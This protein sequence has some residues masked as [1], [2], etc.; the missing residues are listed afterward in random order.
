MAVSIPT[1]QV[2][3]VKKFLSETS[4][5]HSL[6]EYGQN[7]LF[8]GDNI[9][10]L[11]FLCK[12]MSF[13]NQV[14]LIYIDPPY[15][16]GGIF[17]TPENNTA[18]N[19]NY[20]NIQYL[21]FMEGRL[22]LM[23]DLLSQDGSIYLHIDLNMMFDIKL[24]MDS[25]FGIN[26]FKG[27]ITR[28]KCKPKNYTRKTYGNI[29]DYILYYTKS[30]NPT[31]NRPYE[32]WSSE[33]ANKE[34][35]YIEEATNRRYKLVPLHAP[36]IRNGATG[37]EWRGMLPPQGKHWQYV[38]EKLE[39]LDQKGEIHWSRT[40]NPRRKVY[41][42]QSQGIPVQDI[43]LDLL[44]NDNQ[45]TIVTGYPTEKNPQLIKRIIEASSNE[46][47]MVLDCFAGSG[48]T[49]SVAS[50]LNRNWIGV[51]ISEEAIKTI[52]N[53]FTTTTSAKPNS[54]LQHPSLFDESTLKDSHYTKESNVDF[55]FWVDCSINKDDLDIQLLDFLTTP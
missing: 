35:P 37:K 10:V 15:N 41:L 13:E 51:D 17:Q 24:I 1:N 27:L 33:R 46:G 19:D 22:K 53:R 5:F 52:L 8:Y 16:T 3:K 49:L 42:D 4:F 11:H 23:R 34:Y 9:D 21:E 31:W 7:H 40:G 25:V 43:W 28:K 18:Y 38:P 6:F 39:L 44:D 30:D 55:S 45:N 36:G 26:N 48:T 14:K 2:N 32:E 12:N 47:D 20:N 29:S 50:S 54:I